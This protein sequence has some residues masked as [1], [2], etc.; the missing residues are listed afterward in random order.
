MASSNFAAAKNVAVRASVSH[1]RVFRLASV[2]VTHAGHGT[3][4][5]ALAAGVPLVCIPMGRDQNDTAA[6]V[7]AT[8]AGVRLSTRDGPARIRA[9]IERVLCDTT[10]RHAAKAMALKLANED[11]ATRAVTEIESLVGNRGG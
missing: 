5:R 9:A 4:L 7:V 3:V 8:G 11:N 1:G 6:R 10:F 2:V